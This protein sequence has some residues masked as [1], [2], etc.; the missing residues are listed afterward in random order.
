MGMVVR[1]EVGF[2]VGHARVAFGAELA[3]ERFRRLARGFG[4]GSWV[5]KAALVLML[6]E[7][8]VD[9]VINR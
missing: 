1:G 7:V 3:V 5:L 2:I 6:A 4:F 8:I 9:I